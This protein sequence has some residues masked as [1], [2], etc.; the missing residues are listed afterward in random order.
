M[1]RAKGPKLIIASTGALLIF[2]LAIGCATEQ[3][4]QGE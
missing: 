3:E 2:L 1:I 4:R